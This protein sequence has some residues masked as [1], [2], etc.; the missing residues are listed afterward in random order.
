MRRRASQTRPRQLFGAAPR[1]A[2]ALPWPRSYGDI[3]DQLRKEIS[4]LGEPALTWIPGPKT[5]SISTLVIHLLGSEAEV[6]RTVRGLASDRD[7]SAEFTA[8]VRDAEELQGRIGATDRL[9][10]EL[11][12]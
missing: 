12:A 11:G 9:L 3:H 1:R 6:L 4:D 7:R 2:S 5:N 10:E 8:N